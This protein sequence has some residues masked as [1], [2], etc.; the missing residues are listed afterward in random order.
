MGRTRAGSFTP[1]T[2][3]GSPV[4]RETIRLTDYR[5]SGGET[6]QLRHSLNL[7]DYLSNSTTSAEVNLRSSLAPI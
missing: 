1:C 6:T 3:V 4:L 7:A 5:P 2:Q